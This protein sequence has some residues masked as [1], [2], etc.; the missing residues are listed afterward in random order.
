ME[1]PWPAPPELDDMPLLATAPPDVESLPP[2]LAR[3][4]PEPVKRLPELEL[5]QAM[6]KARGSTQSER[7][8]TRAARNEPV[9][10]LSI[11]RAPRTSKRE[12]T[13]PS[14]RAQARAAT[15]SLP[16]LAPM[17]ASKAS[18]EVCRKVLLPLRGSSCTR[19]A[20]R[21]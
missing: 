8:W 15:S 12:S 2:E 19:E 20:R 21:E 1:P 3:L 16:E 13:H 7:Q 10:L 6:P 14:D 11:R 4:P 18:G 5:P 17:Q 9:I